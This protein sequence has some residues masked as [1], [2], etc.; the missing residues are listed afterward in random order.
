MRNWW[1]RPRDDDVIIRLIL[2]NR[3]HSSFVILS[4]FCNRIVSNY[5]PCYWLHLRQNWKR[6]SKTTRRRCGVFA[7]SAPRYKWL[8]L[9]TYLLITIATCSTFSYEPLHRRSRAALKPSR[10]T[11]R[12][13]VCGWCGWCGQRADDVHVLWA[14]GSDRAAG[15]ARHTALDGHDRPDQPRHSPRDRPVVTTGALWHRSVTTFTLARDRLP[16]FTARDHG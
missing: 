12:S 4:T 5:C 6:V 1:R 11:A 13:N 8:Y 15:T 7:I 10:H 2:N 14:A 9:L 3:P 16:V